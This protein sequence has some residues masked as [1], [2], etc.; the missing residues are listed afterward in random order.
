[1]PAEKKEKDVLSR[2][3]LKS[4]IWYTVTQLVEDEEIDLGVSCSEHFVAV[5]SEM[6]F[7]QALTLGKDLESFANH[8]GRSTVGVEDVKYQLISNEAVQHGLSL[9]ALTI[10]PPTTTKPRAK[11]VASKKDSA[12]TAKGKGKAKEELV[13]LS[14]SEEDEN[15]RPKKK[16]KSVKR[17]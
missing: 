17:A 13:S 5:L 14:D 11:P 16:A 15:E 6:V 8:A 2:Q 1:M 9:N 12:A 10:K 7:T 3:A 4:A